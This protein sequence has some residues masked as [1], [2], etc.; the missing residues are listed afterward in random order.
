M[1][2]FVA[3]LLLLSG[4]AVGP[5]LEKSEDGGKPKLRLFEAT[6]SKECKF[7]IASPKLEDDER[8]KR[9]FALKFSGLACKY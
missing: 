9:R 2:S 4:C 3:L 5:R 8:G 1:R 6:I 7:R